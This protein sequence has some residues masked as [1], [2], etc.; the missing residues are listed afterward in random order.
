MTQER[1]NMI[2]G[3]FIIIRILVYE[4]IFKFDEHLK[5]GVSRTS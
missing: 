4:V 1:K 3:E 2:I 5:F